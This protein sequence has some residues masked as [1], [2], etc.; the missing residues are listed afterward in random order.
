M[1]SEDDVQTKPRRT[2]LPKAQISLILMIQSSEPIAC[3]VIYPF[4]AQLIRSTGVNRGDEARVGYYAGMIES[5]F[6]LSE[7]LV[8]FAWGWASD[9]IGRRPILL[10]APLGLAV[11]TVGFGLSKA[12]WLLVVWRAVQGV[13]N[14]NIGVTRTAMAEITDSTNIADAYMLYPIVW[15]VGVT[16]GPAIGGLLSEPA[17]NWPRLFGGVK[18]FVD[19]PY[20]LP[21]LVSGTYALFV[22]VMCCIGL[23]ETHP[24]FRKPPKADRSE[25]PSQTPLLSDP[26]GESTYDATTQE[27]TTSTQRADPAT[28]I[29]PPSIFNPNLNIVLANHFFLAFTDMANAVLIP[30]LYSTSNSM[31]GLGFSTKT[32]GTILAVY[33]FV[34]AFVQITLMKRFLKRLGPRRL[35]QIAYPMLSVPFVMMMS[36]QMLV[37][38]YGKVTLGVWVAIVLQLTGALGITVA[39]ACSH[40]LH[41]ETASPGTLGAVNGFSQTIASVIRTIAPTLASSLFALSLQS[42]ILGGYLVYAVMIMVTLIG[43]VCSSKLPKHLS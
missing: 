29:S 38:W 13:F 10:W 30:I 20:L 11:A 36:E 23:R 24:S 27:S 43:S 2:P 7:G 42:G 17:S 5:I 8:C 40:L 14:G 33:N 28:T 16:I 1:D 3:T 6:F 12:F 25:D 31:G 35:Y 41:V 4:I 32:I 21:C 26:D 18:L 37:S 22:F 39:Y 19:Y 15:E 34:N 9:K